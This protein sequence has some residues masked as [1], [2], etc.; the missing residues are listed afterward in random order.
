MAKRRDPR[1]IRHIEAVVRVRVLAKWHHVAA[2][3]GMAVSLPW[4]AIA[5]DTAAA[6]QPTDA[7]ERV[8]LEADYVYDVRHARMKRPLIA[9]PGPTMQSLPGV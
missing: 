2:A 4:Y 5:Q 8:V 9:E 6:P 1:A 3:L 7:N